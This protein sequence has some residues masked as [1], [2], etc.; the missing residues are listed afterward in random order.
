MTNTNKKQADDPHS[1]E[2]TIPEDRSPEVGKT[3]I[4]VKQQSADVSMTEE[5]C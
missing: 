2:D 5:V 1:P 3:P 4:E